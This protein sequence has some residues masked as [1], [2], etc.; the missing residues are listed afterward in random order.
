MPNRA[1]QPRIP[2]TL[3]DVAYIDG[4]SLAA[5]ADMSRSKF[6]ECVRRGDAPKPDIQRKR[7]TRWKVVTARAWLESLAVREGA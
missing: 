7:F 1:H 3:A 6:L 2:D 5:A 4:P